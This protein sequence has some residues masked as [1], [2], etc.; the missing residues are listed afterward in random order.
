MKRLLP[1]ALALAALAAA[2]PAHAASKSCTRDGAKLLAASGSVRVVSMKGKLGRTETRHDRVLGCWTSTGRRFTMFTAVDHGEDSIEHD[3]FTIVGGR[4]VG[5][6]T[7]IEGGASEDRRAASY[8]VKLRKR[9]HTTK[10]CD[11][12][13]RGD[14]GGIVDVAFFKNGAMAYACNQL[15]IADGKGDRQ[16]EPEGTVVGQLAV[17]ALTMDFGPRLYWTANGVLKSLDL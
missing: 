3:A 12:F 10:P 8:D 5:V 16:L 6:D 9:L 1:V 17:S 13:D 11:A 4:Y 7:L 15:R 2:A 14:V